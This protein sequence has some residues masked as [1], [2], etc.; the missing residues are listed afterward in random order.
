[1]DESLLKS[2]WELFQ[3]ELMVEYS[4]I[5]EI[6]LYGISPALF[7]DFSINERVTEKDVEKIFLETRSFL[8]QEEVFSELV[9]YHHNKH[10]GTL[11]EIYITFLL[12][13]E[14]KVYFSSSD[15]RIPKYD[16]FKEWYVD[17]D[18]TAIEY[19]EKN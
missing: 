11:N 5:E 19:V 18:D 15:S 1:M 6:S 10:R 3:E 2:D 4:F 14:T 12:A 7:I 16:S 13:D 17:I 8:F 9:E